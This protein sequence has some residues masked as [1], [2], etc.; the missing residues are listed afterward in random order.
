MLMTVTTEEVS[1]DLRA[2]RQAALDALGSGA[3]SADLE[4]VLNNLVSDLSRALNS[5]EMPCGQQRRRRMTPR[6]L[7]EVADVYRRAMVDE[8]PPTQAVAEHFG[9]PHTSAARWVNRARRDNF[10][11]PSLGTMAGEAAA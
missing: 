6:H 10:L 1:Y 4:G 5:T 9:V 8:L 2:F 7:G 3:T 11:R